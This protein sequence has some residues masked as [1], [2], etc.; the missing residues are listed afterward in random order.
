M[1][2]VA[3]K[4]KLLLNIEVFVISCPVLNDSLGVVYLLDLDRFTEE[5]FL[6]S[7]K[8]AIVEHI[9]EVELD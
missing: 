1:V 5:C 2:Q 9:L 3:Y 6:K 8:G 4:D 7:F